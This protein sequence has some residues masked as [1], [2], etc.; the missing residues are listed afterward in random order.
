MSPAGADA[1]DRAPRVCGWEKKA[2]ID[3][4]E[5]ARVVFPHSGH[6]IPVE[7]QGWYLK[8]LSG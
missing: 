7:F 5:M 8:D 1:M 6:L 2:G 3:R 4:R